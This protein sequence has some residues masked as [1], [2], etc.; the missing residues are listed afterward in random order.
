MS[1][2]QGTIWIITGERG[3]GKTRFCLELLKVARK[4]EIRVAGIVSPPV[5]VDGIKQ[6]IQIENVKTGEYKTLAIKR[7]EETTGIFTNHWL[8]EEQVINWGNKVLSNATPCE[9]LFVDE[10]G[11]LEFSKGEG[12]LEGLNSIDSRNYESAVVVIRPELFLPARKRWD[13]S[14]FLEI[15]PLMNDQFTKKFIDKIL[16]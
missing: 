5:I 15:E 6:S 14:K 9:L 13:S 8:F 4:K 1:N 7:T 11:P 12:L 3:V 10:L 2:F 16:H